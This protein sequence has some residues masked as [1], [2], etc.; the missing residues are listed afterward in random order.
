M[1]NHLKNREDLVC[2]AKGLFGMIA[3][4]QAKTKLYISRLATEDIEV[5][6]SQMKNDLATYSRRIDEIYEELRSYD[7]I[8]GIS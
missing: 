7:V 4:I 8:P 2:E 5:S 3:E 6:V 1:E